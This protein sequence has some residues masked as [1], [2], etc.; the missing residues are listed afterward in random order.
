MLQFCRHYGYKTDVWAPR[1]PRVKRAPLP[2]PPNTPPKPEDQAQPCCP[3]PTLSGQS[4]DAPISSSNGASPALPLLDK[5]RAS[6]PSCDACAQAASGSQSL[7]AIQAGGPAGRFAS[8]AVAEAAARYQSSC[9]LAAKVWRSLIDYVFDRISRVEWVACS[10]E[11][12][13]LVC[14]GKAYPAKKMLD[15]LNEDLLALT[16][17]VSA[18]GAAHQ[19]RPARRARPPHRLRPSRARGEAV[20]PPQP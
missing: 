14:L 10:D 2:P 17:A 3:V 4:T 1:G 6:L 8:P 9:L 7:A 18:F 11:P 19:A 12:A 13:Y 5:L 15:T 20:S 16:S